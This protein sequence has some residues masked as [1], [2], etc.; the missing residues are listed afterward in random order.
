VGWDDFIR[1]VAMSSFGRQ[2]A[3]LTAK[4]PPFRERQRQWTDRL[5][6]MEAG[7]GPQDEVVWSTKIGMVSGGDASI[8]TFSGAIDGGIVYSTAELTGVGTGVEQVPAAD[9]DLKFELI[10]CCKADDEAVGKMAPVMLSRLAPYTLMNQLG[11]GQ[12]MDVGEIPG[13]NIR[14]LVFDRWEGRERF[15]FDGCDCGLLLC[16][17]LTEQEVAAIPAIGGG[18]LLERLRASDY[19]P[20]TLSDR[21]PLC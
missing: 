11:A 9:D 10:M 18:G 17:A 4:K 16:M 6:A 7:L 13:T 14:G 15:S 1:K 8:V 5:K 19:Y 2:L 20:W 3:A 21:P 12:T